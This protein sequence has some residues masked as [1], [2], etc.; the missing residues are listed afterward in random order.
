[1][2][3][4]RLTTAHLLSSSVHTGHVV[5]NETSRNQPSRYVVRFTGEVQGVGFRATATHLARG[6]DVH[7][8]VRNE[9]DGSVRLDADGPRGDLDELIRR[10]QAEMQRKLDDTEID[11]QPSQNRTGG[12]RLQY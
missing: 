8:Y 3:S 1:M 12:L 4:F 5:S 11:H 6:L 2:R 10:I 9:P 7:G